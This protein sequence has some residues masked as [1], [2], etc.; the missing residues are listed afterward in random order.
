MTTK[1]RTNMKTINPY[2]PFTIVTLQHKTKNPGIPR[3]FE[4][5][6]DIV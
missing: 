1:S 6:D 3:F 4:K 2:L 5:N